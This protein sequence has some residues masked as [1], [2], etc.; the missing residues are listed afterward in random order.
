MAWLKGAKMA[1]TLWQSHGGGIAAREMSGE[2]K[3]RD[4]SA[5]PLMERRLQAIARAF[6]LERGGIEEDK[7]E[8]R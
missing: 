1:L 4:K 8:M 5:W 2:I 6:A 3:C 7:R